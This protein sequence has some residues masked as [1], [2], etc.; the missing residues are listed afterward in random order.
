AAPLHGLQG[1]ADDIPP[2]ILKFMGDAQTV[3]HPSEAG[4]GLDQFGQLVG[5]WKMTSHALYQGNW[6][7]G[8]PSYWAW[9]YSVGGTVIQDYFFQA[10]EDLPPIKSQ[11]FDTHGF[12]LRVYDEATD[13]WNVTW[14][15][16]SGPEMRLSATY[17]NEMIY[18]TSEAEADKNWRIV[19]YEISSD[20]F[21]WRQEF[22]QEDGSWK[23][24]YYLTGKKI[25]RL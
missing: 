18:L 7:S 10:K 24:E 19:F 25:Y 22:L 4:T 6:L 16:N 9:K 20:S 3:D 14:I 23:Y 17:A 5:V 2:P 12:N 15:A 8:W 1:Q 11:D 13:S 21:K